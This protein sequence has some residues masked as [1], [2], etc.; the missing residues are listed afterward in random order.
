MCQINFKKVNEE[1]FD[2]LERLGTENLSGEVLEEE[3]ARSEYL[4]FKTQIQLLSAENTLLL[5][6]LREE[7]SMLLS[8]HSEIEGWLQS[9]RKC[10]DQL[11]HALELS[12]MPPAA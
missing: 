10:L 1:L 2:Q 7:P 8:G 5:Q 6:K 9:Q 12:G 11:L 3:L 4:Y